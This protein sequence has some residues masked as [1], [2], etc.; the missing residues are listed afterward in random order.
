M[1]RPGR[2]R[3]HVGF[4]N[5]ILLNLLQDFAKHRERFVGFIVW[6][7]SQD[8]ANSGVAEYR[9]GYTNQ[10]NA[11][12]ST[13]RSTLSGKLQKYNTALRCD[14]LEGGKEA[15]AADATKCAQYPKKHEETRAAWV[16]MLFN[17]TVSFIYGYLLSNSFKTSDKFA[18]HWLATCY[19]ITNVSN[20]H[21]VRYQYRRDRAPHWRFRPRDLVARA[22]GDGDCI[23]ARGS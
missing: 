12:R 2:N 20:H 15:S 19:S 9:Y 17:H 13:H 4:V 11:R 5:V 14:A 18:I 23:S 10:P 6:S 7:P 16:L 1:Q 3:V 21:S 22:C 8:V